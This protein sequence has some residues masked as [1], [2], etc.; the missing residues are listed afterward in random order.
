M[1]LADAPALQKVYSAGAAFFVQ[2]TGIPPD[3]GQAS[4]DLAEAISDEGRH[5]L[6]IYLHNEMVGVIDLRLA[7]P[8]PFDVRIGLILMAEPYRGQGLGSSGAAI[9]GGMA[10][11]RDAH[12]S[13]SRHRG[14]PGSRRA[15]F[16]S[17]PTI[18]YLQG[19][20]LAVLVGTTRLRL[21][22]MRKGLR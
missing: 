2:F 21:L 3:A 14:C 6:G 4:H 12:R 11:P 10:G 8:E 5:I 13:R 9:L 22:K 16:P 15:A 18:T 7:E 1:T 17:P 20:Q 19:N